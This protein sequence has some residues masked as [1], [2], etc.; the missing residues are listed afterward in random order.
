MDE[1]EGGERDGT[2]ARQARGSRRWLSRR[3]VLIGGLSGAAVAGYAAATATG[4][5]PVD[6]AVQHA[7]GVASS[8][9]ASQL[10]SPRIERV[11]SAARGRM[12]DLVLL[13]PSK[14]PPPGLPMSLMLHGLHSYAR[15]AAPTGLLKQ[16]ATDVARKAVPAYGFVAVDGGDNY[17][18]KVHPGDDPMAMLLEEVPQWLR[19]RGFAGEDGVPFACTGMSMG[20]FGALLYTRRRV[21]R[22]QPP[23]AVATL[24]PALITTWAEMAKRKIFTGIDDWTSLDPLRHLDATKNVPSAVWCG[25]EDPFVTGVRRYIAAE[26]PQVAY[27]AH[28]K[29]GDNFNRTVVP[30]LVGFLGK[31]VPRTA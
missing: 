10:G 22:R 11:Y 1:D 15:N 3:S 8:T 30:S 17:W 23:A 31:H 5:L 21:E 24:A 19:A 2:A 14:T 9:P 29:H 26:K 16:L 13:L 20:G 18:H 28:G 25:T 27:L 6:P 7:L 4:R 12:V